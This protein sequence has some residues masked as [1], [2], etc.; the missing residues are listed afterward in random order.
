MIKRLF[1]D[2]LR[3]SAFPWRQPD[4]KGRQYET[5]ADDH[6]DLIGREHGALVGNDVIDHSPGRFSGE[7]AIGQLPQIF[8]T[9]ID[10]PCQ[11]S[12]IIVNL[13]FPGSIDQ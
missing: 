7:T 3:F 1:F 11:F 9:P 13:V 10:E 5:D 4:G 8:A 12:M 6:H 2:A